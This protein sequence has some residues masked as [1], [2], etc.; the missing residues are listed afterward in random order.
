M[1]SRASVCSGNSNPT[2]VYPSKGEGMFWYKTKFSRFTRLPTFNPGCSI[3]FIPHHSLQGLFDFPIW[4]AVLRLHRVAGPFPEVP[5]FPGLFL[6]VVFAVL[7][8][9]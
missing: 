3:P 5:G 1:I 2:T 7:A 9:P 8:G 4:P 6:P